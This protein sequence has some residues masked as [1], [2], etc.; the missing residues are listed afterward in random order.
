[1]KPF[2]F[3]INAYLLIVLIILSII[4]NVINNDGAMNIYL[5]IAVLLTIVAIFRSALGALWE[6][7]LSTFLVLIIDI[8]RSINRVLRKNTY[9]SKYEEL[10]HQ[11]QRLRISMGIT[12]EIRL[13]IIPKLINAQIRPTLDNAY[14]IV[15]GKPLIR[16][17]DNA[18]LVVILVH[19]LAHAKNKHALNGIWYHIATTEVLFFLSL[20]SF[21]YG[22]SLDFIP[23][24][25]IFIGIISL[26]TRYLSW[27]NEYAADLVAAQYTGTKAFVTALSKIAEMR[28]RDRDFSS[29]THP[30]ITNR[31]DNLKWTSKIRGFKWHFSFD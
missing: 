14:Q 12:E 7:L 21:N 5:I 15:L 27:P 24:I 4:T 19:E 29:F 13:T 17:L 25:F 31:L 11:V 1:V 23:N 2:T 16:E 18:S 28:H 30:S 6:F 22:S 26:S 9:D 10:L 8:K 3:R 20:F